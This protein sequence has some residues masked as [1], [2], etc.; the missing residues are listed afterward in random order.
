MTKFYFLLICL[1]S[2]NVLS[3]Q[4]KLSKEEKE[5]REKNI[6]AGNP[7]AKFG[8]KAKVATLSKGKYL[9]VH[10]LDSIVTI[11]TTRWHVDKNKIVGDVAIDSLN[12]DARPIGDAVG[13]WINPDPLSEEFSSW[14]PYNM[15]FN[16]PIRFIDPDGMAPTDV[17]VL[18]MNNSEIRRIKASGPDIYMKVNESAFNKASAS[19]TNDNKD[20][21]T[22]LSIYSLRSQERSSGSTDLISEQ[23][24]NSIGITGSMREGSSKIGDVTVN[25]QVDFDNG[26]NFTLESFSGVAGG[27]GNG[28]PENGNYTVSNF[29]DRSENGWYNKGM[30]SD[31]VGFSFNLNPQFSTNRSL[32]RIHPDGNNEGTLGCIGLSGNGTELSR[33]SNV[34]QGF[35]QN[36]PSISTNINITGNPNNN[37]TSGTKIPNVNE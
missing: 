34:V 12:P 29:Q 13:R 23:T 15:S 19:F 20:Y 22:M 35:L 36:N 14:S 9:E 27:F 30:N 33:F 7:F 4:E 17:I 26:S 6:Q 37:G 28:A 16:N 21:N 18:S 10:D 8:Y 11:G 3:A 24:G 5:R 32:L 25:T 2:F 1:F 31:G